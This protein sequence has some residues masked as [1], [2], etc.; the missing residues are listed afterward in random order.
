MS[1]QYVTTDF[2]TILDGPVYERSP[3]LDAEIDPHCPTPAE[4]T[5]EFRRE[6][7]RLAPH[8]ECVPLEK[9]GRRLRIEGRDGYHQSLK[10][11][12]RLTIGVM[13]NARAPADSIRN[14]YFAGARKVAAH[15]AQQAG[16]N[17][18]NALRWKG[19]LI[20]SDMTASRSGRRVCVDMNSDAINII[21][22][23]Y[24]Y[25]TPI[26]TAVVES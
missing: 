22:G 6:F 16:P 25:L 17:P 11:Y 7:A 8:V 26:G 10:L 5:A 23:S 20:L 14:A 2:A 15:I 12:T 3:Q 13:E 24:Y 9:H 4:I 18:G 21:L 1:D 19:D